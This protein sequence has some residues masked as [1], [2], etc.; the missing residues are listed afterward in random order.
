ML[1]GSKG[2]LKRHDNRNPRSTS[3]IDSLKRSLTK[4]EHAAWERAESWHRNHLENMPLFV[5]TAYTGLLA[6]QKIE[7]GE[8]GQF[9]VGWMIVRVLYTIN[10]LVTE[11]IQELLS[12]CVVFHRV[13]LGVLCNWEGGARLGQLESRSNGPTT[14]VS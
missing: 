14:M 13:V 1:L 9:V 4:P 12:N 2:N 11:T 6:K 8:V 5:A 7:K 10:S 3:H